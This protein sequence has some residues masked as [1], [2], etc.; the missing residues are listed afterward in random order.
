LQLI[1]A[2]AAGALVCKQLLRLGLVDYNQSISTPGK[3]SLQQQ[4][5][6]HTKLAGSQYTRELCYM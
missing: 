6:K 3:E 1:A 5:V 4:N 2:V